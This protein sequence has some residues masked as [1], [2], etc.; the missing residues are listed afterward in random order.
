MMTKP[1]FAEFLASKGIRSVKGMPLQTLR[2]LEQTYEYEVKGLTPPAE[3]VVANAPDGD[4][5]RLQAAGEDLTLR[6]TGESAEFELAAAEG[7]AA[8]IPTFDMVAYTGAPMRPTGWYRDEPIIVDIEGMAVRDTVPIDSGHMAD[9]G[10]STAVEKTPGNQKLKA[11]GM[12]SLYSADATDQSAVEAR[13]IVRAGKNKFPFQASIDVT[14]QFSKIQF[15]PAGESV[16]ANGRTWPGP[17]SVARASTLNKIAI[18]SR[19]ADGNTQTTIAAQPRSGTMNPEFVAWLKAQDFSEAEIAAFSEK[20]SAGLKAQWEASKLPAPPIAAP[21]NGPSEEQRLAARRQAEAAEDRRVAGIRAAFRKFPKLEG[22]T[23]PTE[24]IRNGTPHTMPVADFQAHAIETGMTVDAVNVLATECELARVRAERPAGMHGFSHSHSSD[25]TRDALEGALLLRAGMRLDN[26]VYQTERGMAMRLPQWLRAGLNND[27]RQ[28]AMEFAWRYR[29]M[30][31]F[32]LCAEALRLDGR[33]VPAGR[34]E[35]IQ[36]AVSGGSLNSIFTTNM[37]TIILATFS[38]APDTTDGWC[39]TTEVADFK[40]NER[41]R[42]QKGPGLTKLP[43]GGKAD[44]THRADAEEKYAIARYATQLEVDEQDIIDDRFNAFSDFAPEMGR[45][46]ARLRPDLVYATILKNPTLNATARALFNA[47]DNNIVTTN[48]LSAAALKAAL[49]R[50]GLFQ[51]NGVNLNLM[52]THAIVPWSLRH[53]IKELL[54]S[55]QIVIAG[56]AGT[57]TERG[58]AN[59][60]A[61]DGL[62]G[63]GDA[64]IENGL[65]DPSSGTAYSGSSSTWYLACANHPTIE[66]AYLRGTGRAPQTRSWVLA[67]GRYGIGW[68]IALDIGVAPLDWRGLVQSTQ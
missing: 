46:A 6:G 44:H 4:E 64:R 14:C 19:G 50:M 37:N 31:M 24:P 62:T 48:A 26:P 13:R 3:I 23:H 33:D 54:A 51:E 65:T 35:R 18:L 8:K 20:K 55:V 16:K 49:S 67:E 27:Q 52:A 30:S 42:L 17:V 10:H 2:L 29:E 22:V 68:D 47:T 57:V 32:D 43:R 7:D 45:A 9:I 36:A 59:T 21:V 58:N 1:T 41:P 34:S 38:E 5:I 15:C 39:S 25:C 11:K 66:V 56:T 63:I 12:L 28:R 60:L 61:D 53:T 40:T